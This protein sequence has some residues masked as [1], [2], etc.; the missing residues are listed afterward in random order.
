LKTE[1][2]N[3]VLLQTQFESARKYER[4][5]LEDTRNEMRLM[6]STTNKELELK[7]D[8]LHDKNNEINMLTASLREVKTRLQEAQDEVLNL[9]SQISSTLEAEIHDGRAR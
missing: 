9:K 7:A 1:K 6:V 5:I 8:K 2:E 4:E 3:L